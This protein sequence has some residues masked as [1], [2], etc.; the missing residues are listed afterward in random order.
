MSSVSDVVRETQDYYDGP[1][2]EIYRLIWGDDVH[3]GTWT[4]PDDDLVTA[5]A[6]TNEVMAREAGITS[7][8]R[9]LDVGC[10]YGAAGIYL[11]R[12]HGCE[13]VGQN[14]SEK[15]LAKAGE[16]AREAGVAD[17]ATFE[18]GDFHDI[19]SPDDSFDVVFS[20]EAL[21]HGVDKQQILRE[22]KRVLRQG[23]RVAFSD[24]LVQA[25]VEE[26]ERE[27]I[28]ARVHS[29]VMWDLQQYVDGLSEA[30]FDVVTAEDWS[31]NVAPTYA[32]VRAGLI[33]HRD[34][35]EGKVPAE[36]IDSTIDALQLWVDSADAGKIGLGFFVGVNR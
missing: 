1:A 11:A 28:Y 18:Y 5:M 14:I 4:S 6:R 21:L 26:E 23:G 35:L 16:L 32:A 9:V 3:M 33:E 13:V 19:P 8:Q 10:G 12:E 30:G 27:A 31:R 15:E 17:R 25:H 34:A 20:Q 24:L 7:G 29:P 22:C 36:Q 2:D